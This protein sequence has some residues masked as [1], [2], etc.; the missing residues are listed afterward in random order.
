MAGR[1]GLESLRKQNF[2]VTWQH[3]DKTRPH[4]RVNAVIP[5]EEREWRVPILWDFD[6]RAWPTCVTRYTYLQT[7]EDLQ[8]LLK[9]PRWERLLFDISVAFLKFRAFHTLIVLFANCTN[10]SNT[11]A[12]PCSTD[13]SASTMVLPY[14]YANSTSL[15]MECFSNHVIFRR[16]MEH[17]HGKIY[18]ATRYSC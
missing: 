2:Q 15:R 14:H 1:K 13:Y 8:T 4:G 18:D 17:L 5:K 12:H 3:R 10:K 6:I 7:N 16:N 11:A 9:S